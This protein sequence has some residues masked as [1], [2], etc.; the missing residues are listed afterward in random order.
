M[1]YCFSVVSLTTA[2]VSSEHKLKPQ[3]FLLPDDL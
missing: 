2:V 1:A 3:V